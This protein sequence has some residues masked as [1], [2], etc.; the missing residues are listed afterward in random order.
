MNGRIAVHGVLLLAMLGACSP[1]PAEWQPA[2]T[3]STSA[4]VATVRARRPVQTAPAPASSPDALRLLD[5]VPADLPAP[6]A[7]HVAFLSD[8]CSVALH[9]D[10]QVALGVVAGCRTCPPFEGPDAAPDGKIAVDGDAFFPLE[11][12]VSGHFS[13]AGADQRLA[14]FSGCE[15]HS[16]NWGGTVLAERIAGHFKV[17]SYA[18][19][20]HPQACEAYRRVDGRDIAVCEFADAHQS[21]ATDSLSSL[22]FSSSPPSMR[23]LFTLNS[24]DG[25]SSEP[26]ATTAVEE[27]IQDF[28][29]TEGAARSGILTV[30]IERTTH[31][32]NAEFAKYCQQRAESEARIEPPRAKREQ[33]L[34]RF[35]YDGRAFVAR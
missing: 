32:L 14:V 30:H 25:C 24:R 4:P 29:F 17:L 20:I 8:I 2:K 3:A 1:A 27:R 26:G 31:T 11:V 19:G 9:H 10:S 7:E 22:D 13:S 6:V 34:R 28:E 35:R 5:A 15:P 21:L 33:L 16:E 23:E 18:S 12:L